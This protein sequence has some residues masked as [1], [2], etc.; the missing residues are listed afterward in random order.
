MKFQNNFPTIQQ[1]GKENA[2]YD[3]LSLERFMEGL[4]KIHIKK[5][6]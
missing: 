5:T 2:M 1:N 3:D 6:M 4:R